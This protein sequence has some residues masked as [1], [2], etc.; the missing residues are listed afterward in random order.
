MKTFIRLLNDE[1]GATA[2]EYLLIILFIAMAI[3]LSLGNLGSSL[4][5]SYTTTANKIAR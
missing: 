5:T 2:L 4:T 3:I 1:S